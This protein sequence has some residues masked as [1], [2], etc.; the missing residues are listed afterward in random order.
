MIESSDNEYPEDQESQGMWHGQM[1]WRLSTL[2]KGAA[3]AYISAYKDAGLVGSRELPID[4][5]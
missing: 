3:S 1:M 5:N 2:N 4:R